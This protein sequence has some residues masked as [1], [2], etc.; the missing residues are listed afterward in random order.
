MR[1]SAIAEMG[2][3]LILLFIVILFPMLDLIGLALKYADCYYLFNALVREAGVGTTVVEKT[4][5]SGTPT[6]EIKCY[7]IT[8]STDNVP[9]PTGRGS[10]QLIIS[11]WQKSGLGIFANVVPGSITQTASVNCTEGSPNAR[12]VHVQMNVSCNPFLKLPLPGQIP[13]LTAPATFQFNGASVVENDLNY[14]SPSLTN[15]TSCS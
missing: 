13:G 14:Q 7:D 12:W 5:V 8:C 10:M 9:P 4:S 1:G 2:P 11:N 3:A 15:C 6:G